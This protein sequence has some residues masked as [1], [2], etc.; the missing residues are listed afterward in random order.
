MNKHLPMGSEKKNLLNSNEGFPT[1]AY[2]KRIGLFCSE[3]LSQIGI[4]VGV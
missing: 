2:E 3:T 4:F 1:T